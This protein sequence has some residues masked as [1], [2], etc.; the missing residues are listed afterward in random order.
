MFEIPL[1]EYLRAEHELMRAARLIDWEGLHDAL[2]MYYS[3]LGRTDNIWGLALQ[4]SI[5]SNAFQI[6]LKYKTLISFILACFGEIKEGLSAFLRPFLLPCVTS[7]VRSREP[8][9]DILCPIH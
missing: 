7:L 9:L 1:S 4:H 8:T 2:S 6:M 5:Y 3:P